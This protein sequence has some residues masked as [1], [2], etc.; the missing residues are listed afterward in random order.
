MNFKNTENRLIETIPVKLKKE[1]TR[2]NN[3]DI[4]YVTAGKGEPLLLIHGGNIGWGQW[5]PNIDAFSKFFRVYALD[6]PGAGRSTKVNFSKLDLEKDF[7]EVVEKFINIHGFK[8]LNVI[9]SS[10]GG[11]ILLKIALR[12]NT[13]LKKLV[14]VDCIG[15]TNHMRIA[16]RIIGIYPLATLLS[17]TVLKPYRE[18]RNI[19]KFLRDIFYN[20]SLPI[21]KEFTDYFYETMENSHNLLLISRLS[22]LWGIRKEFILE[23]ELPEI[24]NEV[25]IIWGEKD[26]LLPPNQSYDNFK[27]IP[28]VQIEIMQDA[29][30]IPSIEKSKEFNQLVVKFLKS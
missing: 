12:G 15:F 11:W 23:R 18:N 21:R 10:I 25:M 19:E 20:K 30:H 14:L 7:V 28:K 16:D 17:K 8:N 29:G 9:G 6:L 26:K 22:S 1:K 24:K 4:N 13:K 3:Y 27:L 2:I 5:Y